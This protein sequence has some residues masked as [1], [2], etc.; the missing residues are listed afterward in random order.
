MDGNHLLLVG[1]C[2]SNHGRNAGTFGT[3]GLFGRVGTQIL[4]ST[5]PLPPSIFGTE[6]AGLAFSFS[7]ASGISFDR[8]TSSLFLL[9]ESPG[10]F[11]GECALVLLLLGFSGDP[12]FPVP[13]GPGFGL[14]FW[15]LCFGVLVVVSDSENLT[16]VS[17]S[18]EGSTSP[19]S[20]EP[21]EDEVSLSVE[22]S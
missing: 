6:E 5:G 20:F 8:G 13:D 19:S 1:S 7:R 22:L 9:G 18:S 3:F 17:S 2:P 15:G 12:S 14:S 4:D 11:I 16:L 10:N 21:L